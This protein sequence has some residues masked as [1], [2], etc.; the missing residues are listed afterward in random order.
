MIPKCLE[1]FKSQT[2]IEIGGKRLILLCR[3]RIMNPKFPAFQ[4][5]ASH[6]TYRTTRNQESCQVTAAG[7]PSCVRANVALNAEVVM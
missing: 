7:G 5:E 6:K 2:Q 3:I 4:K 1:I